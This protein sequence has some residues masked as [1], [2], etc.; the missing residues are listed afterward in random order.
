LDRNSDQKILQETLYETRITKFLLIEITN[1]FKN[2]NCFNQLN[3]FSAELKKEDGTC[4]L[5]AKK[6][7]CPVISPKSS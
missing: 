2:S 5:F 6:N 7:N 1:Q 3:A 4:G